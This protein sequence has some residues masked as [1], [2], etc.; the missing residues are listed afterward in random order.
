MVYLD[1]RRRGRTGVKEGSPLTRIKETV[2]VK[3]VY[4]KLCT[5]NFLQGKTVVD[6]YDLSEVRT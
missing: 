1:Y 4:R 5:E 2:L 6:L 3:Q